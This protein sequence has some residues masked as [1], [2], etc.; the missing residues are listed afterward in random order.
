MKKIDWGP[1][2]DFAEVICG[3]ACYGLMVAASRKIVEHTTDIPNSNIAGYDDAV[4]AIMKSSM[5]SHDKAR[6]A[7]ALKRNGSSEFYRAIIHVAKDSSM[8][9]HDKVDMIEELSQD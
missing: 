7:A 6:A 5:Y 2:K 1:I 3:F 9:S 8:Y 4:G